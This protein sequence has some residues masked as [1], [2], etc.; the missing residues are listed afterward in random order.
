MNPVFLQKFAKSG[1]A[2][3]RSVGMLL[4]KSTFCKRDFVSTIVG[5]KA[6]NNLRVAIERSKRFTSSFVNRTLSTSV[7]KSSSNAVVYI[8]GI[9]ATVGVAGGIYY[10]S[11][12]IKVLVHCFSYFVEG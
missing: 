9:V 11:S 6:H 2:S 12:T 1:V 10:L 8:S 7:E 4:R 5:R 3:T